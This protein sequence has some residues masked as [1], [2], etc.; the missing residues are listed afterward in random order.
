MTEKEAS[1][2][3]VRSAVRTQAMIGKSRCQRKKPV[4]TNERNADRAGDENNGWHRFGTGYENN[5]WH[6]FRAVGTGFGHRC[7]S[8]K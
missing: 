4:P 8:G 2:H 6:R 7:Q 1:Y 5:G 3:E